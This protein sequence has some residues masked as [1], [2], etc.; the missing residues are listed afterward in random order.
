M[1]LGGL[2]GMNY[3]SHD[4]EPSLGDTVVN[5]N[6]KCKHYGSIGKVTNVKELSG[7]KGKLVCYECQN[8]GNHW[9]IGD[10]LEKTMDQLRPANSLDIKSAAL[11][12]NNENLIREYVRNQIKE[13]TGLKNI[14]L[15]IAG[16][17]P[18]IGEFADMANAIDYAKKGNYLFAAFSLISMIP[19]L[20]DAVGKGG[21]L[22]VLSSKIGV[23]GLGKGGKA[24]SKGGK[25]VSAL[26]KS[27]KFKKASKYI[28]KLKDLIVKHK[29]L[30]DK[31]FDKAEKSGNKD[32]KNAVPKM[33][34]ALN[35]FYKEPTSEDGQKNEN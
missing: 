31:I 8:M 17:I 28:V 19:E 32:I 15:D 26:A 25:A 29:G 35:I 14:A 21:K 18:G 27:E 11:S 1:C 20:G 2:F 10:V 9:Q 7:D 34:E 3:V 30:I 6:K 33:R 24:L 12:R 22:Y 5:N 23:K 16:L 13:D 4:L